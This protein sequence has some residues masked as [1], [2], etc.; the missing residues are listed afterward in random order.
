MLS[1]PVHVRARF[2]TAHTDVLTHFLTSCKLD[3]F[4]SSQSSAYPFEVYKPVKSLKS[5]C[6]IYLLTWSILHLIKHWYHRT[7]RSS[8]NYSASFRFINIQH[9]W[10]IHVCHILS[11]I[12]NIQY[13]S[14]SCTLAK[15]CVSYKHVKQWANVFLNC[16]GSVL[17]C[18]WFT[19]TCVCTFHYLCWV[20]W[21]STWYS[22][23]P[24]H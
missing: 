23:C 10:N 5:C 15:L 6:N 12:I 4:K 9:D 2:L 16:T 21:Y 7:A 3:R 17:L 20:F 13:M 24:G 1:H 18:S 11:T 22:T 14:L 8:P 19:G